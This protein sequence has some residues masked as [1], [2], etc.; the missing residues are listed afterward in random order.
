MSGNIW[1]LFDDG[2]RRIE[3]QSLPFGAKIT[4]FN[5]KPVLAEDVIVYEIPSQEDGILSRLGI[6]IMPAELPMHA[7]VV[8]HAYE[9]G[10]VRTCLYWNWFEGMEVIKGLFASIGKE[11]SIL[12]VTPMSLPDP[13][14]ELPLSYVT[15]LGEGITK[16]DTVSSADAFWWRTP[17]YPSSVWSLKTFELLG[18]TGTDQEIMATLEPHDGGWNS[19]LG[20]FVSVVGDLLYDFEHGHLNGYCTLH[21]DLQQPLLIE[22]CRLLIKELREELYK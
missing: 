17:S 14:K 10:V 21:L 13:N 3:F 2:Q 19:P 9:M 20:Q 12:P 8:A 22:E 18:L 16:K 4:A 7:Y 5:D 11:M 1:T 15:T 6:V